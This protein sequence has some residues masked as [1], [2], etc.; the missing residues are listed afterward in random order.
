MFAAH[1]LRGLGHLLGCKRLAYLGDF[2]CPY[3]VAQKIYRPIPEA[4]Q[5]K[6]CGAA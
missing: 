2:F 5:R 3:G 1:S 4:G 6:S